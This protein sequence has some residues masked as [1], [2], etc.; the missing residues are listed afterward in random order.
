MST[1][2][3]PSLE[4]QVIE[5]L[6]TRFGVDQ[7]EADSG[8]SFDALELDSLALV[9]LS[10]SLQDLFGVTIADDELNAEQTIGEA[11]RL[12]AAKIDEARDTEAAAEKAG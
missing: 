4:Q 8:V 7:S 5:L 10:L 12:V 1:L 9:E 3:P 2:P 6:A 11:T